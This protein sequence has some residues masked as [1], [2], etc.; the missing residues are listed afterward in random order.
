[1][2][3]LM[4]T[5]NQVTGAF[6]DQTTNPGAI[7]GTVNGNVLTATWDVAPSTPG[8]FTIALVMTES[9]DGKS[10]EGTFDAGGGITGTWSGTRTGP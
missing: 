8:M 6:Q 5:G 9:T 2:L 3:T 7:T 4:Q 10:F 1:V